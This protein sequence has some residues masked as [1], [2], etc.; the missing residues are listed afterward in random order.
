M[1]F[2]GYRKNSVKSSKRNRCAL[3]NA[4]TDIEFEAN[5]SLKIGHENLLLIAGITKQADRNVKK[6]FLINFLM[7][8]R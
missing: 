1:V 7:P 8:S 4:S 3:Q 5:V 6:K 2:D